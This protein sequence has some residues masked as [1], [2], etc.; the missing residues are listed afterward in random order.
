MNAGLKIGDWLVGNSS[1]QDGNRLV[2]AMRISDMPSVNEYFLDKRFEAKKPKVDGTPEEQCGDNIYYL[3][4]RGR[5]K[6]LPSVF[7][8]DQKSFLKDIGSK[9]AGSPVFV[10]E[11]FYY[12]GRKRIPI[13][14]EFG[15]VIQGRQGIHYTDD[16]LAGAFVAW[17][18]ASYEPG[19]RGAPRDM[20]DHA[21]EAYAIQ[22]ELITDAAQDARH[23]GRPDCGPSLPSRHAVPLRRSGC[24]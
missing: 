23:Q 19:K 7:H 24:R 13:P 9:P 3:D 6:R 8:N 15:S 10:A 12:F 16:P 22:R 14:D 17:L 5:W 18:E 1:R 2:Y 21:A 11:H 20:A 4:E